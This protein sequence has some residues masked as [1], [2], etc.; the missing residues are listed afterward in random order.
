MISSCDFE[1]YNLKNRVEFSHS[2]RK[3]LFGEHNYERIY[4]KIGDCYNQDILCY[5]TSTFSDEL[6]L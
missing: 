5:M 4:W 6:M 2:Y 1:R 3:E